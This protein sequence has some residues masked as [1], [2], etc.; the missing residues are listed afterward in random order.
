VKFKILGPIEIVTGSE[1]LELGGTRQQIVLATLLLNANRVVTLDRLLEAIYGEGLPPTARSQAQI[2]ISSLRRLFA[3]YSAEPVIATRPHGYVIEVGAEQLDSQQFDA[4]VAAARAASHANQLE[5]AVACYRDA[6]RLCR[7]PALDGI[8]SQYI[9][10]AA[11]RLDEQRITTMEDRVN[12]ELELGRHHELVGELIELV[13]E[14]PLREGLRGQLMLALYRCGRTAEALQVYRQARRTMIDELGIEPGERLQQLEHAILTSDPALELPVEPIES[15]EAAESLP[16]KLQVPSL[17]PGDLADFTGRE[18]EIGQIYDQLIPEKEDPPRRAVPV[19]VLVGKGG[20]GKSSIAV[21]ASH[22]IASHFPDGQLYADLHGGSSHPVGPMQVL[23]R[24]LRALGV[25]GSYMPEGLDERAEVY[26]NLLAADRKILIVLDDA[27]SESQV[28]PL[29]PG[30]SASAMI[31]TSRKRLAGIAGVTHVPVNVFDADKSLDLLTRI[32][33]DSRVLAQSEAAAEVAAQCGH[34]P[35][36]LRIAGAKLSARPHWTIQQL[37]DRLDDETRRLDELRHGDMG[38]RPSISLTYEGTGEQARQLFRR[39]ALLDVPV[40]S[41]WMSAALLDM[42]LP[43]AEDLLDD[44]INAQLIETTGTSSGVH[45]HYRF[46]DLI[47][48]FAR[49]RLAAE[50][51]AAERKA[52]LERA[53]GALL[54]LSEEATGRHYGGG[55]SLGNDAPRWPLPGRLVDELVEEPL[56]WYDRE[57]TVLVAGVR[58]A[59]QVGSVELCWSLALSAVTLFES[60]IY[61]DDWRETN[62]IALKAAQKA[63]DVR[64]QAAMLYSTGAL[65][66]T[67]QR[68]D[69]AFQAYNMSS[70]LFTEVGDDRGVAMVLR[71]IALIDRLSGRLDDATRNYERA[72]AIFKTIGDR[73]SIASALH[74]LGR[75]KLEL[76]DID[77][78]KELL[79]DALEMIQTAQCPKIEAQVLHQTGE[80]N[81]VAGDLAE[82]VSAFEQALA[83]TSEVGDTIG[84]AFA[85]MGVGVAKVRQGEF[86]QAREALQRARELAGI[87][88]QPMTEARALLGLGELALTTNDPGQAVVIGQQASGVFRSLGALL[89]D[90]RALMLLSDA[91]TALGDTEA[92]AAALAE[93]KAL[94]RK[95]A[96]DAQLS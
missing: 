24:F 22:G 80:A 51:P 5:Q 85:L 74:G 79:S 33:G 23:E 34:L 1:R 76:H 62:D 77:A 7:G 27:V 87:A 78:A 31:I 42:P 60:R 15:V 37:A 55:D 72:L 68:F 35:L 67:E 92:A 17:L 58:Q 44:L 69:Q 28:A 8:E 86:V 73:I 48:V 36:A 52:A 40:F 14:F 46:H 54:F 10:V 3:P 2:S 91:Y 64:G 39:L 56:S 82:A 95:C 84:E 9:R 63:H 50:E 57:R 88:G 93:A 19:V 47:R 16:A 41:G 21:H 32:T 49:E 43:D 25:P 66:I 61:L 53:L 38:I 26:R 75:V 89:D 81:L 65:Y 94:T 71:H 70:Q 96:D 59:A 6:L 4:L 20:V 45:S 30:S 29:L 12:L 18:H 90:A 11:S 83:R 13:E